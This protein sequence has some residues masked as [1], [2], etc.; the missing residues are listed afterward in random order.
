M[1]TMF[2]HGNRNKRQVSVTFDDGPSKITIKILEILK[3]ENVPA[4]FFV[5]G[6]KVEA[7]KKV[8]KQMI[9]QGCEI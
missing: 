8:L 5:M 9:K 6:S 1:R 7:N 3:R 4:T 2:F